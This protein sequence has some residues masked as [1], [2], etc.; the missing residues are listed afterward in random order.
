MALEAS[1]GLGR[2]RVPARD[3]AGTAARLLERRGAAADM[4]Q[5]AD[6]QA[7]E[8][9][10]RYAGRCWSLGGRVT[11][12]ATWRAGDPTDAV[13]VARGSPEGAQRALPGWLK[14]GLAGRLGV[15]RAEWRPGGGTKTRGSPE[16]LA[17]GRR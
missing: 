5:G 14:P 13:G 12:A 15:E 1:N 8:S 10:S 7:G 16:A 11:T 2:V 17:Y 6:G 4:F 9:G 3:Q